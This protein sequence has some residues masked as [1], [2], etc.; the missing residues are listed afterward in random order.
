MELSPGL[1]AEGRFVKGLSVLKG[2]EM[3]QANCSDIKSD[4]SAFFLSEVSPT[5]D[6]VVCSTRVQTSADE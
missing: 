3:L 2:E 5:A 1:A 6:C 4:V